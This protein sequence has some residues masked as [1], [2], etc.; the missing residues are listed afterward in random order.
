[1]QEILLKFLANEWVIGGA[2]GVCLMLAARLIDE[3]KAYET[4]KKRGRQLSAFMSKTKLGKKAWEKIEAFGQK[5]GGA[6]FHGVMDG[7]D[8][9]DTH[10]TENK[11]EKKDEKTA[12]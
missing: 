7:L 11:E 1:M 3:E 4:G 6:Y 8:E 2:V 5:V 10:P 9:D 12:A